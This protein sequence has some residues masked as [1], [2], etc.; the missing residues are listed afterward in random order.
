M[1]AIVVRTAAKVLRRRKLLSRLGLRKTTAPIDVDT[2]MSRTASPEVAAELRRLYERLERLP[3]NLRT[4]LVLRRIEGMGLEEVA[5][6][7]GV[8]LATAK[9]RI[10][11]AE[12]ALTGVQAKPG[13]EEG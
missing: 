13:G 6:T 3:V 11:A 5:I 9:R 1:G 2:T 8:S 12:E 10:A 4:A 7:L